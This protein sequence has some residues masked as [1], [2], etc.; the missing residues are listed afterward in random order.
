M[1]LKID[2]YMCILMIL[3]FYPPQDFFFWKKIKTIM[4]KQTFLPH[5]YDH[6]ALRVAGGEQLIVPCVHVYVIN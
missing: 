3:L 1:D 6:R 2:R 5:F 4:C